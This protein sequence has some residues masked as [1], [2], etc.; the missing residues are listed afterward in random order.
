MRA[1]DI[2]ENGVRLVV[3]APLAAGEPVEVLLS[4]PGVPKPLKRLGK[5][6]WTRA[7]DDGGHWMGVSFEKP[8]R[9]AELQRFAK[10]L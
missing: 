1:V 8:L 4:G 7:L 9:Y 6:V 3:S 2:S 5:V 10:V